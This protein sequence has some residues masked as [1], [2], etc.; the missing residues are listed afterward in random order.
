MEQSLK[1]FVKGT[2]R[3]LGRYSA[4]GD[5]ASN[6]LQFG[7]GVIGV[8]GPHPEANE[9]CCEYCRLDMTKKGV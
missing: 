9:T 7:S 4:D 5:I 2:G 3:V 6:V 8:V 1:P